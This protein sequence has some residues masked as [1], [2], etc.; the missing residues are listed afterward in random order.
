MYGK[1]AMKKIFAFSKRFEKYVILYG[2]QAYEN[3]W[4]MHG[5]FEKY[6]ILYGKQADKKPDIVQ[7]G[8]RSM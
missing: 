5:L 7:K 8:L 6:V 3:S 1:Q 2:K 4:K